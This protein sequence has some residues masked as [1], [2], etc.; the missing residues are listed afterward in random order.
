MITLN[1]FPEIIVVVVGYLL[2]ALPSGVLVSSIYK[3]PDPRTQGSKSTGATNMLRLGN[4]G[5]AALTLVLDVL[6]GSLAV[7]FALVFVPS[8]A[9]EAGIAAV[10]GHIW[11]L[12]LMFRGGKGVATAFGVLLILNWILALA[13]LGTWLVMAAV[14]RYSSLAA[15][16]AFLLSFPYALAIHGQSLL[17]TLLALTCL[18]FWTHRGNIKRL[19]K[20][21]E[22]KIGD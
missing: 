8:F 14:T 19:F 13:C 16:T 3:L 7:I 22:P 2:G 9:Q 4:K 10:V 12:W 11:P 5:A 1:T 18:I 21:Q 15:L 6:K 17:L 20:G